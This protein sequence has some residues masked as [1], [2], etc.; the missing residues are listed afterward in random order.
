MVY[1]MSA[2][3]ADHDSV[4]H[5]GFSA[6]VSPGHLIVM[7]RWQKKWQKK[8]NVTALSL[9]IDYR[10]LP[11]DS[12]AFA[13]DYNYPVFG[14][15]LKYNRNDVTMHKS[16]DPAWGTAEEVDYDSRLGN[17]ITAY[18]TFT[19][20]IWPVH[21]QATPWWFDYMLGAGIGWG[22]HKYSKGNNVDNELTG[23]RFL[24]Y[25]TA[26]VHA[27]Y[28]INANWALYSGI[29]FYHHSN[30]ALNRPNKGANYWGPVAGVRYS[31]DNRLLPAYKRQ[32]ESISHPLFLDFSIGI[33]GK[34]LHEEWQE[35]QFHTDPASD[36]YRTSRFHF[37]TSYSAQTNLM[38]R[39]ARRW[40]SGIGA[41]LF[42]GTYGHHLPDASPWS[43][44]LAIKHNAYYRNLSV[45]MAVGGYLYRHMGVHAKEIEEPYY[46]RIGIHY[47]FP[48]WGGLTIGCDVK[49][50]K[51]KADLT[52]LVL[53]YPIHLN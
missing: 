7:D 26:G 23:T 46:E 10:P 1:G 5:I 36:R 16:P 8:K 44:G 11:S 22:K 42:Y 45:K 24:I 12:N 21:P 13:A 20:P 40:A 49:A 51:T 39:Y 19:R 6:A 41:D 48:S 34:T 52:E 31:T 2:S 27:N 43:F 33:G 3:A 37:Y 9:E 50:H 17:I 30:G 47:T 25:F 14:F 15:G 32:P 28:Q 53:S 35:T 18:S 4:S 29:E 38:Y